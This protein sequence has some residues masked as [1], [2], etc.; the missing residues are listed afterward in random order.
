MAEKT[1][2]TTQTQSATPADHP[3]QPGLLGSLAPIALMMVVFYFLI[4]RPQQKRDAKRRELIGAA[5]KGDRILTTGG[6]IGTLHKVINDKE[7]SLEIAENV[8]VRVVKEA[9]ASVLE[10]VADTGKEV[11]KESVE[12]GESDSKSAAKVLS[13][14]NASS[15][16]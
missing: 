4:M 8:R 2:S 5:K 10:K 1:T 7:I 15:K 16:K 11:V 13:K 6:I 3:Q 9:I 14:K 12:V